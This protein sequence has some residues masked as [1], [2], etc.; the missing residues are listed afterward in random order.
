[1]AVGGR[2]GVPGPLHIAGPG[3]GHV[4]LLGHVAARVE[5]VEGHVGLHVPVL[6]VPAL[7]LAARAADGVG[8]AGLLLLMVVRILSWKYHQS[9]VESLTCAFFPNQFICYL[10]DL[11]QHIFC[12]PL[13]QLSLVDTCLNRQEMEKQIQ[14]KWKGHCLQ[15]SF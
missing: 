1:M 4:L 9:Q 6:L 3:A 14:K 15:S 12:Q 13:S 2:R 10:K 5:G 8:V 7:Q 11:A